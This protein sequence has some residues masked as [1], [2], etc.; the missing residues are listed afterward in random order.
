MITLA[1]ALPA[2]A[3]LIAAVLGGTKAGIMVAV[4]VNF[5][6]A[7]GRLSFESIVQ[8][9]GPA[10]NRGQA[11]ARFETRFQLGW[12]IAAVLPVVLEIPGSAGFMLV[13]VVATAAV[14]NYVAGVRA[15]DRSERAA[16]HS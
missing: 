4:V 7:I 2:A 8:R 9:D 6:A 15:D 16:P 3:G 10:T 11:F 12:V 14:L 1:L 5:S 13:G